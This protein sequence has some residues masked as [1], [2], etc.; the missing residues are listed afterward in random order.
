MEKT[1]PDKRGVKE[2]FDG[3]ARRYDLLN[4][5]LTLGIDVWW[6]KRCVAMIKRTVDPIVADVATGT[7]D[8]AITLCRKLNPSKIVGLDL[9]DEM[10]EIG[11]QKISKQ[12]LADRI[13]MRQENCEATTL[14]DC[15]CDIV[16]IGFG[17]RNFQSPEKGLKEFFR[18]LKPQGELTI[19]EFSQPRSKLFKWLF[20]LY[21]RYILPLIGR[22]I[23]KHPIAYTYLPQSVETFPCGADFCRMIEE[24]G[25]EKVH[26]KPL[27]FGIATVYQGTKGEPVR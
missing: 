17:I 15:F 11:R 9:S 14:P 7:G 12:G 21:F 5:L 25:F 2:M 13:E 26:H 27:T 23:S 18:I 20:D 6:R 24:A 16:T 8:L 1:A 4:H 19:L 22:C 10:L 3:I